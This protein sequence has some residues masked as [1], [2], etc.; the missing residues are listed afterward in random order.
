MV[1]ID[2]VN[3]FKSPIALTYKHKDNFT[4]RFGS[5]ISLIIISMMLFVLTF[6]SKN[7]VFR[8]NPI[9]SIEENLSKEY[10]QINLT[11]LN[12]MLGI[13]LKPFGNNTNFDISKVISI[14]SFSTSSSNFTAIR[15]WAQ[16]PF[17]N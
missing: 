14:S 7:F 1:N 2:T 15:D 13:K 6:F 16:S 9:I 11:S 10:P 17:I 4:T 12:H 8:I 3:M 5:I